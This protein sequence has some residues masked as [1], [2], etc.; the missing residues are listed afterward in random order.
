MF[1]II[2]ILRLSVYSL[3]WKAS[4]TLDETRHRYYWSVHSPSILSEFV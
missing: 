1:S 2:S 4:V 3:I